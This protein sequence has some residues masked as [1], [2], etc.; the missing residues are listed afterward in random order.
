M[1]IHPGASGS[2]PDVAETGGPTAILEAV[3][4][5]AERFLA[6]PAWEPLIAATLEGLG[7]AAGVSRA[8]VFDNVVE[9]G[10]VVASRQRAEWSAPGVAP[11]MDNPGLGRVPFRPALE[12]W[13][14]VLSAGEGIHGNVRDFPAGERALLE[15]QDIRSIALV[16]VFAGPE[17]WGVLGF[18]ECFTER[19][20][21]H[22][23]MSALKTAAGIVGAAIERERRE[24]VLR[25]TEERYRR[26]VELSPDAIAIHR[27]G[28]V[29]FANG[30]A[31]RMFRARSVDDLVG[32]SVLEF[33]HPASRPGV[34]LR[35]QRLR[36]GS[37]V[38]PI[39]EKFLRVDGTPFDVEV[40]AA[41]FTIEGE[42]AAQVVIRDITDRK[43][44]ERALRV[45]SEYLEALHETTLHLVDRLDVQDLLAAIVKRA[46]AL[47]GSGNGYIY[48]VDPVQDELE[49]RVGTGVFLEHV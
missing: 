37:E 30:R 42:A 28:V 19:D 24:A 10:V 6:G 22:A 3:A 23:E 40:T 7:R 5:A 34:L 44:T 14:P 18:D 16:P 35:L 36:E 21:T 20:W 41:P 31:V 9:D 27:G 13:L 2:V 4:L 17:W 11:Q 12:R 46:G 49:V 45:H 39:E 8:Y 48:V 26:L 43:A 38:P 33:V 1:R 29:S 32:R 47:L 15:P 25:E